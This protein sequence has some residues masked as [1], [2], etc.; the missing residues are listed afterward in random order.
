MND[1]DE[2]STS[3]TPPAIDEMLASNPTPASPD[4]ASSIP[5][6]HS[7]RAASN[8]LSEYLVSHQKNPTPSEPAQ[9]CFIKT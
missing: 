3:I 9:D 2:K 5:I 6:F 8:K 1:V 7:D 4:T